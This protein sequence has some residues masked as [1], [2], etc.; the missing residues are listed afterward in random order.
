MLS[1]T[2]RISGPAALIAGAIFAGCGGVPV[3]EEYGAGESGLALAAG[4]SGSARAALT[5]AAGRF[6]LRISCG[7]EEDYRDPAGNTWKADRA[8]TEGGWGYV[9]GDY[10]TRPGNIEIL[11]TELDP[12]YRTERYSL[13]RYRIT[14]PNGKYSVALHVAETYPRVTSVGERVYHIDIEGER[15]LPDFDPVKSAGGSARTAVVKT[16]DV[17][18]ADGE[19]TI[20]FTPK[21]QN[22]MINGIVVAGK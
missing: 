9:G 11:K 19:L 16:F 17:E 22:P 3:E 20:G 8:F 13:D 12:M 6:V 5:G 7:S 21:V 18:V 4:T 14:V 15:V 10:I 2:A 1:M